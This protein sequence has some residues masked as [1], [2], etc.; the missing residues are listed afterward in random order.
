M[1]QHKFEV[2][3][4]GFSSTSQLACIINI[5][6]YLLLY[7]HVNLFYDPY[8]DLKYANQISKSKHKILNSENLPTII[9]Q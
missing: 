8:N 7:N 3:K 4:E 5:R 1:S 6:I 9:S 2:H